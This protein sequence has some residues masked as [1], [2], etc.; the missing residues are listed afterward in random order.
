MMFIVPHRSELMTEPYQGFKMRR[1]AWTY[2]SV[3]DL[4]AFLFNEEMTWDAEV[5]G[6]EVISVG[7]EDVTC[8]VVEA[9]GT[10]GELPDA[11]NIYYWDVEGK[12]P[13]PVKYVYNYIFLGSQT[14]TLT[15]YT[16]A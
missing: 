14:A 16:P 4:A 2:G 9:H 3:V 5:V 11:T 6:T 8:Y 1:P 13:C 7:G 15:S 12:Y 10:G